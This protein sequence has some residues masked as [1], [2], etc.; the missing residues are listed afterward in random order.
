MVSID[1]CL[2]SDAF[3]SAV[4]LLALFIHDGSMSHAQLIGQQRRGVGGEI[5]TN[6]RRREGW[7]SE[8]V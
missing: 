3:W 6:A 4:A 1:L 5:D 8:D 7:G 2:V